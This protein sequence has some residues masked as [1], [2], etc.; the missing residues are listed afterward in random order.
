[1]RSIQ[2]RASQIVPYFCIRS[3]ARCHVPPWDAKTSLSPTP[4]RVRGLSCNWQKISEKHTEHEAM[5]FLRTLNTRGRLPCTHAPHRTVPGMRNMKMQSKTHVSVIV[6][7]NTHHQKSSNQVRGG[8]VVA[9]THTHTRN[10]RNITIWS[11][12]RTKDKEANNKEG[13]CNRGVHQKTAQPENTAGGGGYH[14]EIAHT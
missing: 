12:S 7:K 5:E 13:A 3:T 1:M 9:N 14:K 4:A 10:K 8:A 2:V 11:T 6:H